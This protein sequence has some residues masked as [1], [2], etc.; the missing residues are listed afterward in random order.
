MRGKQKGKQKAIG[1][2]ISLVYLVTNLK[3][4]KGWN[5]LVFHPPYVSI[6]DGRISCSNLVDLTVMLRVFLGVEG[7]NYCLVLSPCL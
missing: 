2:T 7:P 3:L 6:Q 4:F 1:D 5:T